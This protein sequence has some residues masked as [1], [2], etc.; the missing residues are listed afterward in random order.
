MGGELSMNSVVGQDTTFR[1]HEIFD[2]LH[3]HLDVCFIY[4][5]VTPTPDSAASVPLPELLAAIE[6]LLAGWATALDT[7]Q[8]L[9]LIEAIR[10]QAPHLAD[11]LGQW[12]RDFE[13]D[14]LATLIAP[15]T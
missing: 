6:T 1:E 13:Y 14:K 11:T 5:T 8:I 3:R 12:V 15:E 10:P 4:E 2:A 7:N 9:A